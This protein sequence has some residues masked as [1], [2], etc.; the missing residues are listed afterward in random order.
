MRQ[1]VAARL[2]DAQNTAAM[3]TT[4][5]ECDMGNL[6]ELRTRHQELF[7]AKHQ[8]KLGFMSA[9]VKAA[10]AA[11]IEVPVVKSQ[12]IGRSRVTQYRNH[13]LCR[14]GT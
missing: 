8:V 10:T 9:F 2:K 7:V 12:W 11:L 5:Q 14:R 4:F 1:R 6:M 13:V 3:L